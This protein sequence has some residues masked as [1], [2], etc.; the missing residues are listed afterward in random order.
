M[1]FVGSSGAHRALLANGFR[2]AQ[3]DADWIRAKPYGLSLLLAN[4][5]SF[6]Y[7]P[8]TNPSIMS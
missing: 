2:E 5:I 7:D 4:L 1:V 3:V 6:Y 8:T